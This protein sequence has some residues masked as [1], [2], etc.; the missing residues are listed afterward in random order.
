MPVRPTWSPN[1]A[2][3]VPAFADGTTGGSGGTI[4]D[5]GQPGRLDITVSSSG[6][7]DPSD[8]VYIAWR[9]RDVLGRLLPDVPD[10]VASFANPRTQMPY[11]TAAIRLIGT[12][13]SSG[14]GLRLGIGVVAAPSAAQ[15][16]STSAQG[17]FAFLDLDDT[18][19]GVAAGVVRA[20]GWAIST[21]ADNTSSA[22][23]VRANGDLLRNCCCGLYQ[24]DTSASLGDRYIGANQPLL[25]NAG[26]PIWLVACAYR[27][28]ASGGSVSVTADVRSSIMSVGL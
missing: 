24:G 20:A 6:H 5:G 4:T 26:D 15:A 18:N 14:T 21:D 9:A 2:P 13:P 10:P 7:S 17:L 1:L 8:G 16:V 23:Q 19:P 28:G 27:A 3:F 25:T 11:G 12:A 22:D